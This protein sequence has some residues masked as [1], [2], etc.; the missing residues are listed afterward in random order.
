MATQEELDAFYAAQLDN[1]TPGV[2]P[3]FIPVNYDTSGKVSNRPS[4]VP[5]VASA[6][7]G[8]EDQ[9]AIQA[10]LIAEGMPPEDAIAASQGEGG[11]APVDTQISPEILAAAQAEGAPNPYLAKA[12][13]ESLKAAELERKGIEAQA[14]VEIS[15]GK[16]KEAAG[17]EAQAR[18]SEQ[19]LV[20]KQIAE[21]MD[22]MD[23]EFEQRN[24]ADEEEVRKAYAQR[25]D[26]GRYWANKDGAQKAMSVIAAGLF[27]YLGKGMEYLKR[28]DSL[29]AEDVQLQERERANKISMAEK[30]QAKH[31][32]NYGALRDAREKSYEN[33]LRTEAKI[34]AGIKHT[35]EQIDVAH[36]GPAAM[37][38]KD[39]LLAKVNE[40]LAN[41]YMKQAQIFDKEKTARANLMLRAY[42]AQASQAAKAAKAA[43]E[44]KG[45][46]LPAVTQTQIDHK[47]K[48]LQTLKNMRDKISKVGAEGGFIGTAKQVVHGAQ[49]LAGDTKIQRQLYNAL[50]KDATK[51]RSESA[52][53]QHEI[54]Y[55][56]GDFPDYETFLSSGPKQLDEIIAMET[57]NLRTYMQLQQD[58]GYNARTEAFDKFIGAGSVAKTS[59]KS[60]KAE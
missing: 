29:V 41:N 10:E 3:S 55:F 19:A 2:D 1:A 6:M 59:I 27:G 50:V 35:F 8:T 51:A 37:A 21:S 32:Q 14:E 38:Q 15:K 18:A 13:A 54:N 43:K 28:L 53:Q 52:L 58:R 4:V 48:Y 39:V 30:I 34:W 5:G 25:V 31:G 24:Q 47:V 44:T 33:S 7:E 40:N 49:S 23:R 56:Q 17:A 46:K 36:A 16:A 9:A 22:Q 45:E 26:P 57:N 12:E 42:A 11:Q 20:Q 60:K